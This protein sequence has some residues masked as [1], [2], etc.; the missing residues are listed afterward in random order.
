MFD[1]RSTVVLVAV[2]A[3]AVALLVGARPSTGARH[4]SR[5][6]VQ[7]GDTLWEIASAYYAGDPRKAIWRI[8]ERNGLESPTIVPGQVHDMPP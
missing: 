6:V 2:I 4:E 7:P 5:Y 3:L 1:R 8:S